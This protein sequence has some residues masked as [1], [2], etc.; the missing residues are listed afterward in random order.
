M[1]EQNR[2]ES[3]RQ[4]TSR[5]RAEVKNQ[6]KSEQNAKKIIGRSIEEQIRENGEERTEKE[7]D[8]S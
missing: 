3:K 4:R 6:R 2:A 7:T 1:L 5:V 8:L